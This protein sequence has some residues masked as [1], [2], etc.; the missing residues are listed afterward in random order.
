MDKI[1]ALVDE[2]LK[3]KRLPSVHPHHS[4]LYPLSHAQRIGIAEKHAQLCMEKVAILHKPPYQHPQ[5]LL[6][7]QRLRIG[8][9]SSDFG[10]HPS[11]HLMYVTQQRNTYKCE[12]IF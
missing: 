1:V 10:A 2:Q 4:M 8:Y 3:R 6:Q 7:G 11:S 12:L 9:V 5:K